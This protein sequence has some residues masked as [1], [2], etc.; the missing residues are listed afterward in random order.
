MMAAK[1]LTGQRFGR[2]LVTGAAPPGASGPRWACACDCGQHKTVLQG[3]L[4][5]GETR[6]CGCLRR[7]VVRERMTK[8]GHASRDGITKTYRIWSSMVAR[9]TIPSATGYD[10]YGA[11]GITVCNRWRDFESFLADMGEC[12]HRHEI[13]R[14][15]NIGGNY[16]PGNCRW[17]TRSE[18]MQNRS[19]A[20]WIAF[21]GENLSV[22]QWAARLGIHKSSLYERLEK[23]PVERALT[24][25]CRT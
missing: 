12:P 9:C 3:S 15:P 7:E 23:W 19:N 13:D 11:V 14:F 2:L 5:C 22:T 1:D 10:R 17:A 20:H 16:E 18:Q 8:H 6:S 21:N 24:E 4:R 25:A